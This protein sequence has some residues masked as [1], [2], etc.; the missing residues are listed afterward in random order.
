MTA[1]RK[2]ELS[3]GNLQDGG[4]FSSNFRLSLEKTISLANTQK[5]V[6]WDGLLL[7]A[8]NQTTERANR[9]KCW[10]PDETL[11]QCLQNPIFQ[12]EK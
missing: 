3:A 12:I 11:R 1:A 9:A 5:Q 10:M 8:R 2:G 4:F 6:N 7:T